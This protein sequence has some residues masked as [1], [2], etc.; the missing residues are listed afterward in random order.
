MVDCTRA[1]SLTD[2]FRAQT[3]LADKACETDEIIAQAQARDMG[4]VI[5]PKKSR[6]NPRPYDEYLY[7]QCAIGAKTP[8]R[9]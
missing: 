6:K 8:F 4:P 5:P 3:L 1:G 9:A 7:H 2:G